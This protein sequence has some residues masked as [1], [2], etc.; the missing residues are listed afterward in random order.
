VKVGII[1]AG[2]AGL[3]AARKLKESGHEAVVF[4]KSAAPGGRVATRAIG[5]YVFDT[6]ATVIAPRG[7]ELERVMLEEL[8]RSDLIVIDK[9]VKS[10]D[11]VRVT[12]PNGG[13]VAMTRYCYRQG[14]SRLG[15]LLAEGL[16]VRCLNEALKIETPADGG[17]AVLGESFEALVVAVPP[18]QAKGLLESARDPRPLSAVRFRPCVTL[19]LGYAMAF[20]PQYH[21]LIET[22]QA[23]P[24]TWISVES[25]KAPGSR[26]PEGHCAL[27]VQTGADYSRRRFDAPDS[28]VVQETLAELARLLGKGFADPEVCEVKRWRYSLPE[29]TVS[30]ERANPLGTRLVV[31]GDWVLGGRTELAFEAG[32]AAARRLIEA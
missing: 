2:L 1:G 10:H 32:E 16:D 26:A 7:M 3:A 23:H 5:P 8:D 18:E 4:E 28:L 19:L 25:S 17:Y 27:V 12:S 29:A 20:D 11:G 30:F 31:V 15:A 22:E 14:N 9:P 21:S 13:A 6:G 24:L